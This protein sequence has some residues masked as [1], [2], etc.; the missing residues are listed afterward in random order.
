MKAKEDRKSIF[1]KTPELFRRAVTGAIATL[2]LLF[3]FFGIDLLDWLFISEYGVSVLSPLR[4]FLNRSIILRLLL[5]LIWGWLLFDLALLGGTHLA[6]GPYERFIRHL[7]SVPE[8][9]NR[10]E[11]REGDQ[12]FMEIAEA[13]NRMLD[14]LEEIKRKR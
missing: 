11:S 4:E 7:N 1:L 13:Y 5:L 9:L 14:R 12:E 10:F 2:V 3:V 8:K 6:R